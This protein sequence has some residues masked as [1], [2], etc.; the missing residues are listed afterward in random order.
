MSEIAHDAVFTN[1]EITKNI[2]HNGKVILDFENATLYVDNIITSNITGQD[3]GGIREISGG[4]S[5]LSSITPDA[6]LYTEV[7]K[8]KGDRNVQQKLSLAIGGVLNESKGEHAATIGGSYNESAGFLSTTIGGSENKV[9]GDCSVA[10]GR[11]TNCN[12]NNSFV[13]NSEHNELETTM[14]NQF[15]IGSNVFFKLPVSSDIKTHHIPDG[16][17]CWC[18][19]PLTKKVTL[20]TKQS[21]TMYKTQLE[22]EEDTIKINLDFLSKGHIQTFVQNPDDY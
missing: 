22:T 6:E 15:M 14:D 16:F 19:D 3:L 2:V 7:H 4:L 11:N 21:D 13:F 10:M 20:K 8:L 9:Y 18:W 5:A 1:V 17:A 12:H